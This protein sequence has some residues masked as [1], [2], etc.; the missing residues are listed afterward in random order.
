MEYKSYKTEV[1]AAMKLHKKE[2]CSAVGTLVVAEAQ[3]LT[4]VL[5]GNLK[6]SETY[7]V[8][9]DNVGVTVGVTPDAPYGLYVEKGMG[10]KAQPFLEPGAMNAIPKIINVA[11]RVYKQMGG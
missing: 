11:E 2:F 10:Q 8:M 5:S 4:P 3:G 6:R 7:E 9:P 1:L